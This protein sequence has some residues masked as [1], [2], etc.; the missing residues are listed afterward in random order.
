MR[1]LCWTLGTTSTFRK[2]I[3][4]ACL[5]FPTGQANWHT[6]AFRT[7]NPYFLWTD[8]DFQRPPSDRLVIY[9]T[10]VRD[11][12]EAQTFQDLIN[13][14]DYLEFMGY[15]AI[16]L[17]PVSEFEGNSELGLQPQLP[18]RGRQILWH[19][20]QT[21]GTRQQMPRSWNRGHLGRCAQ[22]QL[23]DRPAWCVCTRTLTAQLPR[24][25]VVQQ[26]RQAS[27]QPRLRF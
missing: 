8:N 5:S 20:G 17:M 19:R 14:L 21:Q 6:T 18:F 10:L 4:R 25:P 22:P 3:I 26:N 13:Q 12:D 9:E 11:F 1:S 24:Q 16:E 2:V 27:F 15:N 7:D 23:W